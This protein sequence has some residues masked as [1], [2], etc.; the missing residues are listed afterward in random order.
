MNDFNDS[1][2]KK[3]REQVV[4]MA[5]GAKAPP[6]AIDYLPHENRIWQ[7]VSTELRPMW[8]KMVVDEVLEAREVIQLPIERVPQLAEVSDRLADSSGFVFRAVPG[9]ADSGDFFG[10]LARREFLSTQYLRHPKS[11]L[12]TPEPDIIHEVIGHGTC[13]ADPKLALLHQ[14]AGEALVRVSDKRSKQFVADV[15]W[16]SGEFGVIRSSRGTKAFGAGILSSIGELGSFAKNAKIHELDIKRM[17]TTKYR[18]DVLQPELFAADSV[19]HLLEVVGGFFRTASDVS[20]SELLV[21]R[22]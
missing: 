8:D 19:D 6:R 15:W 22:P 2:M 7:L 12:Y 21:A 11:P 3:R 17:G 1:E 13:L 18:I 20:I 14:L 9:L 10:A 4:S 16:F 5:A